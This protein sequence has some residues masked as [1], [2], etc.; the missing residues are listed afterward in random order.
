[1]LDRPK[2]FSAVAGHSLSPVLVGNVYAVNEGRWE[3]LRPL[4]LSTEWLD[5][6]GHRLS[7]AVGFTLTAAQVGEVLA[8]RVCAS[9]RVA[10]T[11][12]SLPLPGP[13]RSTA[14]YL[15]SSCGSHRPTPPPYD[16]YFVMLSAPAV[17]NGWNPCRTDVWAI[18]T[19]GEPPLL[20]SGASWGSLIGEAL[21]QASAAT[22]IVFQRS[23][24]F[25]M[26]PGALNARPPGL[27]LTFDFA[28]TPPGVAGQ[29]GPETSGAFAIGGAVR[30]D[31]RKSWKAPEAMTVLLHEIG[32]A[33]G[34][35]HPASPPVPSPLNE[36]MDSGDYSFTAYQPGDLCGLFEVTWQ[37]PCAGAAFVTPG[38]GAEGGP[39]VGVASDA[40]LAS[41]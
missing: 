29:G 41:R 38:L 2:L 39:V 6:E 22:G 32:H 14:D 9:V 28:P 17:G 18:D 13:V 21:A 40:M 7:K 25:T 4:S 37:R 20:G 24:D 3:A 26:V 34:L 33:L 5:G 35:G 8:A 23:T 36:V 15:Q 31:S 16:S 19:Y 11:C 1:M 30:L 27:S 10:R 12:I